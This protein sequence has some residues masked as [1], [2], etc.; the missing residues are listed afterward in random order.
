MPYKVEN[1]S[2][3]AVVIP[4]RFESSRLPGKPLIE[5]SGVPMIV[6]TFLQC[7]VAVPKEKIIVATDDERIINVCESNNIQ[8]IMTPKTCLTG[9]DRVAWVAGK[10]D[11]PTYI[12][13]QGD[14]PIF[15]P[16]D[17]SIL[18]NAALSSPN[19]LYNGYTEIKNET[20]YYSLTCPKVLVDANE[21]LIYMSRAPVPGNKE[22]RFVKAWKQ[23]C[24]YSFPKRDLKKFSSFKKKTTLEEIE[25]IEILRFLELGIT[26][27]MLA[28]SN[29]SIPVDVPNDI[30]KV[31]NALR[32]IKEDK[33]F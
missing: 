22:R 7:A 33:D 12:N 1:F 8:S 3:F 27:K 25:D 32:Y 4:A 21:N 29:K 20:D 13:V 28:M 9:T 18:L 15:N 30:K 23:I 26:V 31:E 6:R 2:K 10:I 5:I 14:E 16:N 19:T 24:A 17:L 11:V